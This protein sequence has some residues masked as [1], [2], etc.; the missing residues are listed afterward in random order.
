LPDALLR[1]LAKKLD[2]AE[3]PSYLG[4]LVYEGTGLKLMAL[5]DEHGIE[6]ISM[7]IWSRPSEE[8]VRAVSSDE[9]EVFVPA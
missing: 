8:V 6:H 1:S 9:V 3:G 5:T 4:V 2:L 7:Q